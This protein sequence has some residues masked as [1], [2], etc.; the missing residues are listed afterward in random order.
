MITCWSITAAHLNPAITLINM[1]RKTKPEGFEWKWGFALIP[2]QIVG[3]IGGIALSWWFERD[4]G[5]L[6]INHDTTG[7]Y[8]ISEAIG[9]E[10][11]GSVVFALVYLMQTQKETWICDCGGLRS[12]LVAC[13]Y[14]GMVYWSS[15]QT[16]GSINPAYGAIQDLFDLADDGHDLACEYIYIYILFPILGSVV[17]WVVFE[18]IYV[19]AHEET[20]KKIEEA[21]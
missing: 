17:A 21:K 19:Q 14:A 2:C 5:R 18:F 20:E 4:A 11:F 16:N 8:W 6:I 3:F 12:F 10:F 13:T 1:I 15:A 7:H 9:M